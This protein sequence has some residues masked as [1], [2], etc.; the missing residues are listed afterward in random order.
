M[1]TVLVCL[2]VSG[3]GDFSVCFFV[4]LMRHCELFAFRILLGCDLRLLWLWFSVAYD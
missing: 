1:V 4:W 2:L 3:I